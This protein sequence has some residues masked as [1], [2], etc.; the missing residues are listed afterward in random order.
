LSHLPPYAQPAFLFALNTGLRRQEIVDLRW[1][2]EEQ[3]AERETSV[4][5]LPLGHRRKFKKYVALN[6]IARQIIQQQRGKNP[7]YVFTNNKGKQFTNY[8]TKMF[9]DAWTRAGL[10]KSKMIQTGVENL[11]DT[12]EYRLRVANVAQEDIEI[13]KGSTKADSLE[14]N[15]L[16]SIGS[17][18]DNLEKITVRPANETIFQKHDVKWTP[19]PGKWSDRRTWR[20]RRKKGQ[21]LADPSQ[22][23]AASELTSMSSAD[24]TP[25]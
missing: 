10:P 21:H 8:G 6:S 19:K 15:R 1:D 18:I 2:Q 23:S 20:G 5:V 17:M 14:R 9:V 24:N 4:F 13:L 22:R 12:F 16:P 11:R 25:G 7:T 3:F